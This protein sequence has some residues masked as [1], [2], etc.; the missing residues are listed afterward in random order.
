MDNPARHHNDI[1]RE[2]F[3]PQAKEYLNSPTYARGKDLERLDRLLK[4]YPRAELLDLGDG[5]GHV[6]CFAAPH[7]LRVTSCGA[8]EDML[9]IVETEAKRRGLGNIE[10]CRGTAEELPF[11]GASFDIVVSRYSAHHWQD[12][13]RVMREIR[14]VLRAS[15]VLLII[16]TISP[17]LPGLDIYL[18]T[19]EM[20]RDNSHVRDYSA[21]TWLRFVSNASLRV[22][23]MKTFN[24]RLDFASYTAQTRTPKH[25]STAILE[26]QKEFPTTC[27]AVS[28]LRTTVLSLWT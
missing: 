15:G 1:L 25:F 11:A 21:G 8:G 3:G 12:P 24:L 10:T 27:G 2:N 20:L 6:A 28:A 13:A 19:V 16:D 14:R 17:G 23:K 9:A 7:V 18:Q 5:G 4:E 26:L 22:Y